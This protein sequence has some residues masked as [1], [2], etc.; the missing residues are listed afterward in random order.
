LHDEAFSDPEIKACAGE[1]SVVD[2]LLHVADQL[3][4]PSIDGPLQSF[5]SEEAHE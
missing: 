4:W 5:L 2:V 3:P 1:R